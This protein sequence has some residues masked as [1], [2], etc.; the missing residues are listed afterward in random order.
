METQ[1]VKGQ[2]REPGGRHA[3]E[4]LRRG[5]LVPAVLYGHGEAPETLA[6][7]RHD[8]EMVLSHAA[9]IVNVERDGGTHSYLIKDLQYD[10]LGVELLHVDLMRVDLQE[11]V[12]VTVAVEPKGEPKGVR[13]G[14]VFQ[15][16]L[17]D[18]ELEGPMQ[19]IPDVL[20]VSV[21]NIELGGNLRVRELTLPAGVKSMHDD[22][23]VVATVK[24]VVEREA[25]EDEAVEGEGGAEPEVISRGKADE[26]EES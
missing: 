11:E 12:R 20:R 7:D 21:E 26:D 2:S 9:H 17:N 5:G 19:A 25:E 6:L 1:T 16:M 15:L 24:A 10:H 13:E 4:R 18:I 8:L 14:G 3:N 22:D 23:D